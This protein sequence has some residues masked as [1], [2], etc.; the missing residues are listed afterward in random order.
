MLK[1]PH[2]W[3]GLWRKVKDHPNSHKGIQPLFDSL[4]ISLILIFK[5]VR[6]SFSW[7]HLPPSPDL[8]SQTMSSLCIGRDIFW[9][10]VSNIVS[11]PEQDITIW[12]TTSASQTTWSGPFYLTT[13]GNAKELNLTWEIVS[14]C[15]SKTGIRPPLIQCQTSRTW[16]KAGQ[17]CYR[18]CAGERT[19]DRQMLVSITLTLVDR[20][21]EKIC[22][23]LINCFKIKLQLLVKESFT[24]RSRTQY[25]YSQS[26]FLLFSFGALLHAK[27]LKQHRRVLCLCINDLPC[28]SILLL[29][30]CKSWF[31]SEWKFIW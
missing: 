21:W 20:N 30:S 9:L 27:I 3:K 2:S 28:T 24:V 7:P 14:S 29:D 18:T 4:N 1:R 6:Y 16:K 25:V 12:S 13:K 22:C 8:L 19:I 15:N 31:V 26:C 5:L 10:I 23:L 11:L 17:V